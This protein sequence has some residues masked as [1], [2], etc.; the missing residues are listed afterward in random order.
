MRFA[1]PARPMILV[2]A[3]T[4]ALAACQ[5]G[6]TEGEL[7]ARAETAKLRSELQGRDSL[8]SEMA[9]SF[10]D[11]EKNIAL[12]DERE[13]L[14]G[15]GTEGELNMDKRKKIVRDVQLMT[16]L[17]QESR[18]RITELT[19]RLD[20]SKIEAGGLRKK[21]KE[22]DLMLASRDSSINIMKEGLLARDFQI[23]QVN[24]QLTAMELEVAK[25]EAFIEQQTNEMNAA[26]YVV[27]TSKE[28]EERGVVTNTGGFIGIGKTAQ[29]NGDVTNNE[30]KEVDVR[31]M[32][33]VPLGV[34]KARLVS[35]HPKN[36]YRIVEEGD[37][38]AYLEI[39]DPAAFWKLSRYMVVEVK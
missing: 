10:D 14:L 3:A 7:A 15:S 37:E 34:K 16:G 17:V 13:K 26:W 2:M 24:Q 5:S 27:G 35:E 38:L 20:K 1:N 8:I 23:E 4:F 6:P 30:F 36:S 11:I 18:E 12:V 22:L 21:L 31:Q 19:K 29:L 33:R 25:R 39:K 9:L 32:T 28:L